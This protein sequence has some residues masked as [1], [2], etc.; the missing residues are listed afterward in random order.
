MPYKDPANA[1]EW[2]QSHKRRNRDYFYHYYYGISIEDFEQMEVLQ[3]SACAICGKIPSLDA[4]AKGN[5]KVLHVDHDHKT[6]KVRGLL[7]SD[8]NRGLGFFGEESERLAN[9][10]LYL[11]TRG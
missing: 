10:A 6:S 2:Q 1:R 4:N 5:Q 8:C 9:A 3:N 7:C 11:K